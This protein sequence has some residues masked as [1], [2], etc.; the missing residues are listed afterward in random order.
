METCQKDIEEKNE[1]GKHRERR[2][3]KKEER[4]TV[5]NGSREKNMLPVPLAVV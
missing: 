1:V 2:R 3:R 4:K 5:Q